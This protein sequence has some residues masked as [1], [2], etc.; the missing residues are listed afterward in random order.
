M[1]LVSLCYIFFSAIVG[2]SV[3]QYFFLLGIQYTSATFACAF[4]NMVP[5]ITFI[6]VLPFRLESVNIKC[7]SGRAKILGT[8][9]CIGGALLLTLY[10]GKPLFNYASATSIEKT[11]T[12][13]SSGR[14]TIGV[15]ALILGTL[16]CHL[17]AWKEDRGRR[18]HT[19]VPVLAPSRAATQ[20]RARCNPAD[21][22]AHRRTAPVYRDGEHPGGTVLAAVGGRRCSRR[23]VSNR[24][25]QGAE[26]GAGSVG[27]AAVRWLSEVVTV[28]LR[29]LPSVH[30]EGIG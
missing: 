23:R 17:G 2:A 21:V 29:G 20:P 24:R 7:K 18:V 28:G 30:K 12:S 14:W 3:T 15:V 22:E 11:G 5:V 8:L 19:R 26:E 25:V 16:F 9:V 10:K 1:W 4:I 13:S 27:A 6:M